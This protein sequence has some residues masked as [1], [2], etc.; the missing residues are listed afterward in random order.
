M[1]G[2]AELGLSRAL[3]LGYGRLSLR[4]GNL[5][6]LMISWHMLSLFRDHTPGSFESAK[7]MLSMHRA[8]NEHMLKYNV[9]G[10]CFL[11]GLS[12]QSML[13]KY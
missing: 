3:Q 4:Y 11:N 8:Y 6:Y 1:F 9:L 13:G 10:V 7:H 12:I 2:V 5:G